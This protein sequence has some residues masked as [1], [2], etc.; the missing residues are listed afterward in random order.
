VLNA[1]LDESRFYVNYVLFFFTVASFFY[2]LRLIKI[3]FFDATLGERTFNKPSHG[4]EGRSVERLGVMVVCFILLAF[5]LFLVQKPLLAIQG[6][7][8]S[9]LL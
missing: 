1:L 9:A 8:L 5:Y 7:A 2:Y 6:E 3:L 4:G